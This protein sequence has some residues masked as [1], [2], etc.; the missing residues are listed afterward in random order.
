[1]KLPCNS[2]LLINSIPK[3]R[4]S[5]L[6][7]SH[8]KSF[9]L[10]LGFEMQF[11]IL[12]SVRPWD[13]LFQTYSQY[14]H[15]DSLMPIGFHSAVP[16]LMHGSTSIWHCWQVQP[17]FQINVSGNVL[18]SFQL[19]YVTPKCQSKSQ[20]VIWMLL[21]LE[22]D[23]YTCMVWLYIFKHW[24]IFIIIVIMVYFKKDRQL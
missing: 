18:S 16:S 6:I 10:R 24:Y 2:L 7:G 5:K 3:V 14:S 4:N 13:L 15:C 19:P 22:P 11:C 12:E 20:F 17:I 9:R 8:K 1:M 23:L 21:G